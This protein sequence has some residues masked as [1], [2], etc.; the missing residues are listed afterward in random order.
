M[1]SSSEVEVPLSQLGGEVKV[2]ATE[3]HWP[4][5]DRSYS[6]RRRNNNNGAPAHAKSFFWRFSGRSTGAG[7]LRQ[8]IIRSRTWH[9]HFVVG[10]L[11]T[12]ME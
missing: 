9:G 12:W 10:D 11:T 4:V 1:L 6:S 8:G 5:Q 2:N 3:P 7:R